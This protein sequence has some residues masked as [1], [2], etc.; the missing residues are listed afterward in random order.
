MSAYP[1]PPAVFYFARHGA[2]DDNLRGV[3]CGGDL[4]VRLAALGRDQ[5]RTIA[6]QILA[7]HPRV[8]LIISSALL[9]TRETA[10][11]VSEALE[12]API[13]IEPLLNERR[14]GDW[15]GQPIAATEALLRADVTPPGGESEAAFRSRITLALEALVPWLSHQPLVI[16]SSGVGRVLHA[17]LGGKERLRLANAEI[18]CFKIDLER[19]S[20]TKR[21]GPPKH[22]LVTAFATTEADRQHEV[23]GLEADRY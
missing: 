5:A 13:V 22:S 10:S 16:G 2:T 14:L 21:R 23:D 12:G 3:R 17:L 7:T 4:D 1:S 9:R 18:V 8:G 11:I 20:L 19:I 15:N 6:G